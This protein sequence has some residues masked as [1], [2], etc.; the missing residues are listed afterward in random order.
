MAVNAKIVS[1]NAAIAIRAIAG[2]N[3]VVLRHEVI[4]SEAGLVAWS[5]LA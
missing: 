4:S 3:G 2:Q 1:G 5:L